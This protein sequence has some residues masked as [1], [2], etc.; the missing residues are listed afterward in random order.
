MTGHY[1]Q[2]DEKQTMIQELEK[3]LQEARKEIA[4]LKEKSLNDINELW[5]KF[6]EYDLKRK[7]FEKAINNQ[8]TQRE[9]R[10]SS[11]FG[12]GQAVS[13]VPIFSH[14]YNFAASKA[15]ELV[16]KE[17]S[18]LREHLHNEVDKLYGKIKSTYERIKGS[19]NQE[20][21]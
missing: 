15:N 2:T 9:E 18:N 3:Q 11:Q 8:S 4:D 21:N 16:E 19:Y 10:T 1:S 5:E 20:S 14:A 6:E 7:D 17:E 13:F 12:W